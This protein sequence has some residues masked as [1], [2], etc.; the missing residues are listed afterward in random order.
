[1]RWCVA[2]TSVQ[3]YTAGGSKNLFSLTAYD[4][5]NNIV[6]TSQAQTG[7]NSTSAFQAPWTNWQQLSVSGAAIT[8]VLLNANANNTT[9]SYGFSG[10]YDDLSFTQAVPEP[11]AYAML[12]AGLGLLGCMARRRRNGQG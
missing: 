2:A 7:A 6:G 11:E 1:V 4:A 9:Y 5:S 12:L 8:K 3:Y 10:G